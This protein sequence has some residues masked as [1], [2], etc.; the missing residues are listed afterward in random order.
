MYKLRKMY[1]QFILD[2]DNPKVFTEV[3][4]DG[5][6]LHFPVIIPESKFDKFIRKL[7]K[8]IKN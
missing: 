8:D 5:V 2:I 6:R 7:L 4:F 3:Y 1:R